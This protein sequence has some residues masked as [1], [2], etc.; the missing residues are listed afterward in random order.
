MH[1]LRQISEVYGESKLMI[2]QVLMQLRVARDKLYALL[3]EVP[4]VDESDPTH[5]ILVEARDRLKEASG[6]LQDEPSLQPNSEFN[7]SA[8][9]SSEY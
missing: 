8:S 7:D 4:D 3:M 5:E 6:V 9:D 2:P 1:D